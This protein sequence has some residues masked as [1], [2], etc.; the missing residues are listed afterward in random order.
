MRTCL[1]SL[2]SDQTIPNILVASHFRPDFLLFLSTA[3]MEAKGKTQAILE[4]LRLLGMDYQGRY[5]TLIINEYDLI[6]LEQQFNRWQAEVSENY[7]FIVNLTGGTKMMSIAALDLF[8]DYDSEMVYVPI[9]KNEFITPFPKRRPRPPAPLT[10]RLTVE[11][12]LCAYGLEIVNRSKL[13]Q[14]RRLA[15]ERQEI[16]RFIFNAYQP[17]KPLLQWFSGQLR[18]FPQRQREK[19]IDFCNS[20][21]LSEPHQEELLSK[22]GFVREG[23][24]IRKTLNKDEVKYLMGGWLEERLFLALR[25]VLPWQADIQLNVQIMDQRGNKN[26]LDVVFTLDNRLY[27]VECKSLEP[28]AREGGFTDFLYKLG[29]LRQQ[30]GLTPTGLLATTASDILDSTGQVK[31]HIEER[32]RQFGLRVL[33]LLCSP[34]LEDLLREKLSLA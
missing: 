19:G 14:Y 25:E 6:D 16:S 12:Y 3:Y 8:R 29:A 15:E 34:S 17:L 1:V 18:A 20:C 21:D 23:A 22:L 28:P 13:S 26:E 2:V 31:T 9:S 32:A 10:T 7:R 4:T 30:F 27:L 24:F 11:Q 33:P 5:Q